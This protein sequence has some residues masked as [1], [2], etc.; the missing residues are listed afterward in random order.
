MMAN[1]L[2][3]RGI[4]KQDHESLEKIICDTW[5]Y[6]RFCSPKTA[7]RMAKLY[8]AS[9]LTNQTFT[10]VA[11]NNGDPVGIIMGKNEKTHHTPLG[12]FILELTAAISMLST[13]EGRRISRLFAD[14]QKLDESLLD[15]SGKT[16]DAELAFFAVRS[17]QRGT[18]IGRELFTRLLDYMKSQRIKTFYLYTDSTCNFGFYEHQGMKRVAEKEYSLKPYSNEDILFFL[19]EYHI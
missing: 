15:G 19:Y 9:C 14:F 6:E 10:L 4:K 11:I 8:I 18:G 16:F 2:Y 3:F 7:K 17:D 12:Y 1:T 5:A 13:R